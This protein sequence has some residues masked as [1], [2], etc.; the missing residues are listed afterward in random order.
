[1]ETLEITKTDNRYD[2]RPLLNYLA[3]AKNGTYRVEITRVRGKR[4]NDQNAWLWGCIYPSLRAGLNAQGW[5]FT[6]DEQV[7]EF[8]K[9][10]FADN[11]VINRDT[12]EVVTLPNSTKKWIPPNSQRTVSNC[13]RLPPSTWVSLSPTQ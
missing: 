8:C 11:K 6:D 1:M 12:G 3:E 7:H 10:H 4:S 13:A 5:E 2:A 9:Q